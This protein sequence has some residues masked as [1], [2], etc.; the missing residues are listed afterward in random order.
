MLAR[1]LAA[2]LVV[3]P[4]AALA[5]PALL[6]HATLGDGYAL[7]ASRDGVFVT[8]GKQRARVAPGFALTRAVYDRAAHRAEV[9]VEDA[10]C[11]SPHHYTWT[12][13]EL[14]ARLA[15]TA[16]FARLRAKD[17]AAAA[18]GFARAA[19]LDPGWRIPAYNLASAHALL[20][21]KPAALA[22][23]APWLANEPL[24]TYIQVATD[25]DLTSLLDQ[26]ALA[27]IR[28]PAPTT[29]AV[30]DAGLAADVVVAP[31]RG[32]L[33][34]ARKEQSWGACNYKRDLELYDVTT[35]KLLA[36][37]AIVSWADTDPDCGAPLSAASRAAITARAARLAG[38]LG[39]LG[40]VAATLERGTSVAIDGDKTKS[41]LVAARLGVVARDGVARVLRGDATLAT[42]HVLDRLESV[43]LVTAPRAVVV[44]ST[45]P[46]REGCEGT[47]PTQVTVIPL[48]AP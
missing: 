17:L 22:A 36:S 5:E 4:T 31:A 37:T 2:L 15:N 11:D 12:A 33:A 13:A 28:A 39:D 3:L 21:D 42:A 14:D 46:G 43:A 16:A 29:T 23:L 27:A 20:G 41:S 19:L 1:A 6:D 25:P 40:F 32:W 18:R 8:R 24:A 38:L 35:G 45:R 26:P 10:S 48:P 9:D 47:D 30:T 7:H 44:R 34:I